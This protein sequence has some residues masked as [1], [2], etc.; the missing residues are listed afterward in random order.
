MGLAACGSGVPTPAKAP[1]VP[2]WRGEVQTSPKPRPSFTLTTTEGRRYDFG[3]ETKARTTLLFFGYTSCPD[4]CPVHLANI[5]AVLRKMSP[6]RARAVQ[7]VFVTTD[8]KR[9]TPRRVRQW[10]D[11]FDR[12]FVGLRGSAAEVEAAQ[13]AAGVPPA[14]G[15]TAKAEYV[16]AH[17]A[18][19][20]AYARDDSAHLVYPFGV[21]QDDWAHDLPRLLDEWPPSM[22]IRDP[23]VVA[24][25]PDVAALYVELRAAPGHTDTLLRVETASAASAA[26]HLNR[27]S[28]GLVRME[29]SGP[30]AIRDSLLLERG[31][32]HVMLHGLRR[33]LD[34][35]DTVEVELIFSKSG[36]RLVRAPVRPAIAPHAD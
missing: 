19:L 13:R 20:L 24:P 22:E 8:P 30:L 27:V 34:A 9:D 31:G 3:R 29:P 36:S 23:Y 28:G 6:E 4:I 2:A 17:A 1:I 12:S 5:A 7:V 35:G 32:T 33:P 18:V 25:A 15:D 11:Q 21:R 10:L 16:V 14:V 26:V